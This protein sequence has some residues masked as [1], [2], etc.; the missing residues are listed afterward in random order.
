MIRFRLAK[1][2]VEQF[3]ILA[4]KVPA[5]G[6]VYSVS[7]AFK[8]A[9]NAHRI[10]CVF[11]A[12]FQQGGKIILKLSINCQFEIHPEDWNERIDNN[13]LRISKTDLGYLG[14]QTVG[15]ARGIMFSKTEGTDF[16]TLILPPID[17]TRLLDEDLVVDF[18]EI[19]R[20]K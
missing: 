1:I 2:N 7:A 16:G 19:E 9:R 13:I 12:E 3:A 17:L 20:N 11:S 14:N 5:E 15:V 6:L 8:A 10:A 18:G 4:D